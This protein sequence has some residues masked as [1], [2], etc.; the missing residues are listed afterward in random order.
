MNTE[1]II[2]LGTL[3]A[4]LVLFA[5]GRWRY[6]LVALLSLLVV[7]LTG[8]IAPKDA[9]LGFAHPAVI[10]VAAVLIISYSLRES[11]LVDYLAGLLN[12]LSRRPM[13]HVS[14]LTGLAAICSGFM[15]NIGAL[16]LLMPVAIAT[17]RKN[18]R[19]PGMILMPLSFGSIL[20]GLLTLIGTPPNIIIASYRSEVSGTPFGLF[21]FTPVGFVI[22]LVGVTFVAVLGW[23]F[24]PFRKRV[25]EG[26]PT[27]AVEEYITELRIVADS[28]IIDQPLG[29]LERLSDGALVVAA[30]I[31][32]ERKTLK[33]SRDRQ[34]REG[35][36]LLVQ[37]DPSELDELIE[38]TGLEPVS[39]EGLNR[40]ILESES[41]GLVEAVITPGSPLEGRTSLSL[42]RRTGFQI[43]LLALARQGKPVR[44][45]LRDVV[46]KAGDLLLLQGEYDQIHSMLPRLG[47]LPLAARGLRLP[48]GSRIMITMSVF[49]GALVVSALGLVPITIAFVA[50]VVILALTKQIPI[51]NLYQS[52]DMPVI[53]LL[54]AMIPVGHALEISGCTEL[55]ADGL[56][57]LAG[58]LPTVFLLFLIMVITM[59][60]SDIINNA[61]TAVIM[62]PIAATIAFHLGVNPDTFLMGVAIAASC[63]FLTPIGHQCNTLVM[64][65]GG[66]Q[67]GDYWRMGL[68]LEILILAA[69][70]PMLLWI[71]PL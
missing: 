31:R 3:V 37:G 13:V 65:P 54:A 57:A 29:E 53:V 52:I 58:S 46:L 42:R 33:P 67:F 61:A 64:G 27:F 51:K 59:T 9:F 17:A 5:C 15:N 18:N 28:G 34:L 41:V 30:L 55:F 45:R 14:A 12:P 62:A 21:D 1:Q 69:G 2:V 56:L 6:D 23:R 10:T 38:K 4:A 26:E 66:Y 20:G 36:L 39:H 50:A 49:I 43:N 44:E 71:W 35:D 63:A 40:E 32:G 48:A 60:L 70:I 24:L 68:P 22:A 47:C 19:S 8:V 7:V 11:G 25:A 16:A